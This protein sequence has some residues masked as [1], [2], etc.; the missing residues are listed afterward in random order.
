MVI[1]NSVEK[2]DTECVP[3][4]DLVQKPINQAKVRAT[5]DPFTLLVSCPDLVH[6]SFSV[7]TL[8]QQVQ[9]ISH[10]IAC[11]SP[12]CRR[13]IKEDAPKTK[14]LIAEGRAS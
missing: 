1:R 11:T 12:E 9:M 3:T 13:V 8:R 14:I 7:L 4:G 5:L 2:H 10:G 6:K